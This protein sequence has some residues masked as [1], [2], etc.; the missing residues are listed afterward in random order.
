MP[1][2]VE[3]ECAL[4]KRVLLLDTVRR[5]VPDFC[6]PCYMAKIHPKVEEAIRNTPA[7]QRIPEHCELVKQVLSKK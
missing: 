6:I 7:G 2:K 1:P 3:T 5:N 4:C